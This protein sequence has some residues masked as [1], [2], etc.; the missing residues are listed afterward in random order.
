MQVCKHIYTYISYLNWLGVRRVS[1]VTHPSYQIF[2]YPRDTLRRSPLFSLCIPFP[3]SLSLSCSRFFY[4]SRYG[5]SFSLTLSL[6]LLRPHLHLPFCLSMCLY[7]SIFLFSLS[8]SASVLLTA[9]RSSHMFSFLL[10]PPLALT[11]K[12]SLSLFPLPHPFPHPSLAPRYHPSLLPREEN[13]SLSILETPTPDHE[14]NF[15]HKGVNSHCLC[16]YV[17]Y[18]CKRVYVHVCYGRIL[19]ASFKG[20]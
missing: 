6:S 3:H 1:M 18:V 10:S 15:F 19:F 9:I 2:P 12:C 8:T 20:R 13:Y 7:L 4:H 5:S 17:C 11:F 16:V 14:T